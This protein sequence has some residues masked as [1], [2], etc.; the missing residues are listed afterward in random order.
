MGRELFRI[1]YGIGGIVPP[2]LAG[3]GVGGVGTGGT[4]AQVFPS[5]VPRQGQQFGFFV[6]G[7]APN[8]IAVLFAALGCSLPVVP[9]GGGCSYY[10]GANAFVM[11]AG[12]PTD[13]NG[14]GTVL[15]GSAT[16]GLFPGTTLEAQFAILDLPGALPTHS[17]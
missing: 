11:N 6:N 13:A 4:R 5:H 9:V 14:Y 16:N 1:P 17:T 10:L 12:T 7:A 3:H 15:L 8:S 2:V